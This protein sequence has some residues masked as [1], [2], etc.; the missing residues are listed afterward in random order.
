MRIFFLLLLQAVFWGCNTDSGAEAPGKNDKSKIWGFPVRWDS[1]ASS[2][3][4]VAFSLSGSEI[5]KFR[6][7]NDCFTFFGKDSIRDIFGNDARFDSIASASQDTLELTRPSSAETVRY[8]ELEN[9]CQDKTPIATLR[10]EAGGFEDKVYADSDSV[11]FKFSFSI[12]PERIPHEFELVLYG[13]TDYS[14]GW[15]FHFSH[16]LPALK[17]EFDTTFSIGDLPGQWKSA[18]GRFI[19]YGIA[20]FRSANE[21]PWVNDWGKSRVVSKFE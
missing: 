16:P 18:E 13:Q 4:S 8:L 2:S 5:E 14:N 15:S 6:L 17:G 1:L 10:V 7:W 20:Y 3:D 12:R 11:R 19:K 9:R 21:S